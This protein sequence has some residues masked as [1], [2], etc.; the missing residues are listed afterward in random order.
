MVYRLL[1]ENEMKRLLVL[2]VTLFTPFA[3]ATTPSVAPSTVT[4]VMNGTISVGTMVSAAPAQTISQTSI[5][6]LTGAS[7]IAN[8]STTPVVSA[9]IIGT[10]SSVS[11]GTGYVSPSWSVTDYAGVAHNVSAMSS[12][13]VV[14]TLAN[15][16]VPVT[17]VNQHN[18]D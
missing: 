6:T 1:R 2:V 16:I 4:S 12:G 3:F 10:A 15:V 14:T 7:T 11:T 17:V 13:S 18:N 5:G 8:Q 9:S